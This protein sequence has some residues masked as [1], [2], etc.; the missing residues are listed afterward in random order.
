MSDVEHDMG[1]RV[2]GGH[3]ARTPGAR[4]PLRSIFRTVAL[5]L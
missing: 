1:K 2:L 5:L 3:A 4:T